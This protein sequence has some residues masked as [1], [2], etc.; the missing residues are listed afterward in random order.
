MDTSLRILHLEDSPLDADLIHATL[1]E[2]GIHCQA[3]RVDTKSEFVKAI[4]QGGFELIFADYSLP[5]FDGI[6]ALGIAKEKCSRSLSAASARF[7]STRYFTSRSARWTEG[8]S[9]DKRCLST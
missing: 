8:A 7:R 5:S 3:M 6:S 2:E 9:R 4:D 1:E